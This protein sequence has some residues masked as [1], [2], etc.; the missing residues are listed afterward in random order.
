MKRG[1]VDAGCMAC[2]MEVFGCVAA[3]RVWQVAQVQILGPAEAAVAQS[4]AR[5]RRLL[6]LGNGPV[7]AFHLH[8][9]FALLARFVGPPETG[10]CGGERHV[11][12]KVGVVRLFGFL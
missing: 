10:I 6:R 7:L 5:S 12:I 1:F 9:N 11:N 8:C 2:A 4:A 3:C